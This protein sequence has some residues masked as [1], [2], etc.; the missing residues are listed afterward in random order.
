[1]QARVDGHKGQSRPAVCVGYA[2]EALQ[3]T[4]GR[5][6]EQATADRGDTDIEHEEIDQRL[7]GADHVFLWGDKLHDRMVELRT[8]PSING[9]L[10]DVVPIESLRD[11]VGQV[12]HVAPPSVAVVEESGKG[13]DVCA[14]SSAS[15]NDLVRLY[16]D[17]VFGVM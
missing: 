17:V 1:V 4:P 5:S 6:G 14:A 7:R 13:V 15:C 16:R 9:L 10:F 3:D 12:A 2:I 8:L 11:V